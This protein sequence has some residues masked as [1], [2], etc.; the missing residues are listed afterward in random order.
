LNGNKC[1]NTGEVSML[2]STR[3][4]RIVAALAA[5]A[6]ALAIVPAGASAATSTFGSSLNHEPA[7]VGTPCNQNFALPAPS[8]THVGSFYPGTSGHAQATTNGTIVKIRVRPMSAMTMRFQLVRVRNLSSNEKHGQAKLI[9]QTKVLHVP[10]PTATQMNDGVI[11]VQTLPAHIP[12]QKGEELAI[13]TKNNQ[14]DYCSDGTPG[15]LTFFNPAL[16][17]G[18]G[19]RNNNGVDG[20]LLL[21]Q[22]VVRH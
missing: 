6:G 5:I 16:A 20:C 4:I 1:Q 15:Q 7:N 18:V 19:F 14:A 11:P 17:L 8:C 3:H 2:S 13:T 21:V 10:G 22:A 12:V 9:S